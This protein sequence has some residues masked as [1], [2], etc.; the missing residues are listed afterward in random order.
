M[1]TG[2]SQRLT[3][4]VF[5]W[6][7]TVVDFGSLAP[8]GAF[9]ELF[10]GWGIELSVAEARV[11][12]GLPKRDHIIELS[13][14]PRVDAAW[15]ARHGAPFSDADADRALAVFEPM[16]ARAA[17]ER[18]RLVP[19]VLDTVAELRSRGIRIGTTTGY[20]RAIMSEVIPRAA[21]RGFRPDNVVC[22]DDVPQG[23]PS[24][25][26]MYRCFLDLEVWPAYTV[27][28]VDDTAPGIAEGL[29]AGCWTVGVAASGNATG[30]SEEEL[31]ALA[32]EERARRLSAAY[33]SLQ[34]TGAH[35]VIDSVA[36]LIPVLD[37][38]DRELGFGNAPRVLA[39]T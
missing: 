2:S 27:V 5:D 17:A 29:A 23:R 1:K 26:G 4:V 32:P 12:M 11:P 7:G 8:L 36:D 30:L 20:T 31:Q 34:R 3:A 35:F 21:A 38:I 33:S 28:K 13:R 6:A 14:L 15:R 22:C 25:L 39:A 19:G 10:R 18:S 24:P 16:S 9:V 37:R